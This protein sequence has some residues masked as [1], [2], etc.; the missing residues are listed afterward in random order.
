MFLEHHLLLLSQDFKTMG[1]DIDSTQYLRWAMV[2]RKWVHS[3]AL[4]TSSSSCFL[5][6]S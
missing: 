1:G 3:R 5:V 4:Q 2:L 6:L